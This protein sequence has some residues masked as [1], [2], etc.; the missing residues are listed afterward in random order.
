[1][2]PTLKILQVSYTLGTGGLESIIQDLVRHGP[3]YGFKCEC[4][5]LLSLG[6]VAGRVTGL[7]AAVHLLGKREGLDWRMVRRLAGLIRS[8]GIDLI[9]AHN[10]GPGLYAGLAARLCR[11]PM[12]LTRHGQSF[13]M[14]SLWARRT[15][16]FL[17]KR[18]VA[19]SRDVERMTHE[20]DRLPQRRIKL[21]HNGVDLAGFGALPPEERARVRSGLGLTDDAPLVISVGR[22]APE[23][24]YPG[25][26]KAVAMIDKAQLIIAGEGS[27]APVLAELIK[28]MGLSGRVK[29]PGLRDDVSRLLGA[30]DVFALSSLSEGVSMA[31]LEAMAS[32]LPAVAT[33]VGGNPEVIEHGVS[34]LLVPPGSHYELGSA[35]AK[36]LED[37]ARCVTMGG[38]ARLAIEKGFSLTAMTGAYADLYRELA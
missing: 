11:R 36:V 3:E 27:E 10:E 14:D 1:M 13:E 26:I 25:L 20:V 17:S 37:E 34:G 7:G 35:L 6:Q 16:E 2:P 21:I 15:A 12:V 32:G 24:D 4:A 9:H 33:R 38:A 8:R 29:L 22:L 28:K 23:K 5:A 30:A 19:V 18:T 31:L